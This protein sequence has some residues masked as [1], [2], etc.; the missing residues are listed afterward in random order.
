MK[1]PKYTI[2]LYTADLELYD[3]IVNVCR[4][5]NRQRPIRDRRTKEEIVNL[6]TDLTNYVTAHVVKKFQD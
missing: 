6:A 1:Y 4:E 5:A 2:K 3:A